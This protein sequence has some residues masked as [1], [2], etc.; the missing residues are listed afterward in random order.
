[1]ASCH[2][3]TPVV[4]SRCLLIGLDQKKGKELVPLLDEF[5][6]QAGLV[7]EKSH[8]INFRYQERVGKS[9]LSEFVYTIGMGRFGAVLTYFRYE[10]AGSTSLLPQFDSFVESRVAPKYPVKQCSEEPGFETPSAH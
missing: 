2:A 8:P 9:V 4:A 7:P 1:M 3:M 6:K 10:S 5:S